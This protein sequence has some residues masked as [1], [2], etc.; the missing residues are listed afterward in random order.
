MKPLWA[1]VV[2]CV[3]A[4]ALSL[5]IGTATG[6]AD[7]GRAPHDTRATTRTTDQKTTGGI[8]ISV[9]GIPLIHTGSSVATTLGLNVAIAV[10]NSQAGAL[11]GVGNVVIATNNSVAGS[12]GNFNRVKA[13]NH[14]TADALGNLNRV[15][16]TNG[17]TAAAIGNGNHVTADGGSTL[18]ISGNSNRITARCGGSLEDPIDSSSDAQNNRIIT[19]APCTTS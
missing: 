16:A 18:S 9:A 15:R 14:S 5:I 3:G 11:S 10:N 19:V 7:T 17:S 6:S 4:P 12:F 1:A 2:V 13:D 8:A